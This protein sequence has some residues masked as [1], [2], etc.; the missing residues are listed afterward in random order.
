MT[1]Q[2]TLRV[3]NNMAALFMIILTASAMVGVVYVGIKS[4][5]WDE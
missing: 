4:S 3:V 5:T 2:I 1:I